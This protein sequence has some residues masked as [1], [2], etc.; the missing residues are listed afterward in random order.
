MRQQAKVKEFI[1]ARDWEQYHLPK[2]LLLGIVEEIGEFRNI[3]KWE[4]DLEKVKEKI[5]ANFDDVEDFFG[6]VMFELCSLANYCGVDIDTALDKVLE[7]HEAR[8]PAAAVKGAH[9]NE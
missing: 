6:D 7:R 1:R 3:V 8:Y 2:E 9:T 4:Q 5:K